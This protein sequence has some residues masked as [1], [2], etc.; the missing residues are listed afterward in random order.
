[1][2]QKINKDILQAIDEWVKEF[3]V[4]LKNLKVDVDES[5]ANIFYHYYLIY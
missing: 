4:D 2:N 3:N 1:M 5:I